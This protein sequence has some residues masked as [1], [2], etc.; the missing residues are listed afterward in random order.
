VYGRYFRMIRDGKQSLHSIRLL[1]LAE[2]N[3][4]DLL[5][6]PYK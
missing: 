3:D 1:C 2:G 5:D 4:P 6:S